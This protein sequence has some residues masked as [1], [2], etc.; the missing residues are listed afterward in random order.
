LSTFNLPAI[1]DGLVSSKQKLRKIAYGQCGS[2]GGTLLLQRFSE[3]H[4]PSNIIDDCRP[5]T[6]TILPLYRLRFSRTSH[7]VTGF[8]GRGPAAEHD[9]AKQRARSGIPG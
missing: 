9:A 3:S 4:A 7:T 6:A 1:A 8:K 5:T 2:L